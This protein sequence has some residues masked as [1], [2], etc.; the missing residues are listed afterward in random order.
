MLHFYTYKHPMV[1]L[2]LCLALFLATLGLGDLTNPFLYL[3]MVVLIGYAERRSGVSI[4][5]EKKRFREFKTFLIFRFG[6][7]REQTNYPVTTIKRF[8]GIKSNQYV[9]ENE[10]FDFPQ[11]IDYRFYLA[12]ATHRKTILLKSFESFESAKDYALFFEK[13]TFIPYQ[14]FNPKISSA[15][16][17]R[18]RKSKIRG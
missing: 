7:W 9:E 15:T 18:K 6:K 4:N 1:F 5:Y 8:Q 3:W 10:A 14:R 11:I 17:A 12:T 2:L 13:L 16:R